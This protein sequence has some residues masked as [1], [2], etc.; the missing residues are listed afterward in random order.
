M[1]IVV[2]DQLAKRYGRAEALRAI[3]VEIEGGGVT[4]LVGPNGAGKSTLLKLCVGFE[5]PTAGRVTVAGADPTRDRAAAIRAIGYVPQSPTLYRELTLA[6]HLQLAAGLR[7]GFDLAHAS[8]RL[9]DL[10]IPESSKPGELSG[11]QAAQVWLAIA[12]G[13]RAPLLL[14][15]EPLANLDPL[16]RREF[17]QVV[18]DAAKANGV[19]VLLSSHVI[20]D[21]EPIA[22]RLL[23]LAD[24]RVL[25]HDTIEATRAAHRTLR[26]GADGAERPTTGALVSVFPERD[27]RLVELRRVEPGTPGEPSTLE[28]IVLGYL[29]SV[30]PARRLAA[31]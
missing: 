27:G 22:D 11:G 21:V 9:D 8:G 15:D 2:A 12:L 17:L 16:A 23:L 31:A 3:S 7:P 24:G 14:L 30:R 20:S 5:R 13:T 18:A 10:G 29:A 6:E 4:A 19:T 28:E 25:A 1:P 26:R